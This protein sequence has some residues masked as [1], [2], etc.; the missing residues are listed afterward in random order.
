MIRGL[1]V[2][3][4]LLE[5]LV[6]RLLPDTGFGVYPRLAA[7]LVLL[8]LPGGLVAEALGRRS[9][10]ATLL[11]T[12]ASVS[13][14][15]AVVFLLD[16]SL[17]VGLVVLALVAAGALLLGRG[18][19]S[20][21]PRIPG[22]A[23]VA[24]AGF[25]F[26]LALWHVAGHVDGDGL[27]HLARTRRL[28]ELDGLELTSLNEFRDGSLHPGYAFPLWHGFIGLL[29]VLAGVDPE[30]ALLHAP[31]VLA[32]V[33]FVVAFEAGATLFRSSWTGVAALVGSAAPVALAAGH[34]GAFV[35]LSLPGTAARQL[36][37]PAVLALVFAHAREP[38][39]A[40]LAGI[41][42]GGL[43]LALIHPTYALFLAV[44]LA[45][46]AALRTVWSRAEGR[47]LAWALGAFVLPAGAVLVALLPL[48]DDTLARNPSAGEEARAVAQ[49]GAQLDVVGDAY[50]LAPEVVSRGGAVAVAAL[51]LL[52]LAAFAARS[53]WAALVL[54]G[55]L[56]LFALLLV[57][58]LFARFSDAV[59]LSQSRRAAG[60]IPLA[61]AFAGGLAVLAR[62]LRLALPPVALVAGIVLQLAA[63]GDFTLKLREGGGPAL[64]T[65]WA[66]F[67]GT[68]ALVAALTVLRRRPPVERRGVLVGAAALLFALPVA[69][70][71]V[72]TWSPSAGR[73]A[74]P[75]TPGLVRVLRE[76]VPHDTVVFSDLETSYRVLAAA[77]VYVAAAPPAHVANTKQNR[78]YKRRRDVTRFLRSGNLAYLRRYDADY[79]LI[80]RRRF[81]LR[82]PLPVVYQDGRYT[83]FRAE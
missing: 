70:H 82:P 71:A 57:P 29:A 75:L 2:A 73:R 41:A 3:G 65:W 45:G 76:D 18:G 6:A 38:S 52:P 13:G 55:S 37:V 32:P 1:V 74:G 69:V 62:P 66:V 26:G 80:D 23:L 56:P 19:V 44:P 64:V 17:E 83:L 33:A 4:A 15:L 43:A 30:L 34:G 24:A 77:P 28:V 63:P 54:G 61:F 72:S 47:R 7:A 14:A 21:P 49:Y 16:T 68:A 9:M 79:L 60:F 5:L 51:A 78:P 12:L 22:T 31:S 53:R 59:S 48:A 36:V 42:A 81:A 39:R 46:F 8:L 67:G 50:R 40:G 27:F 58:E 25:V 35:S 10:A 20:R 11:W